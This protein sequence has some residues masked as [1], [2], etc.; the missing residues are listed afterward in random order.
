MEKGSGTNHAALP[1][2]GAGGVVRPA[3]TPEAVQ[4]SRFGD[5]FPVLV[6]RLVVA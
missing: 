3:R 6:T 4:S 5:V 2:N 1:A